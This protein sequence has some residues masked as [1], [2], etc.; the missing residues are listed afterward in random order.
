[1]NPVELIDKQKLLEW[2]DAKADAKHFGAVYAA[3]IEVFKEIQSS[4]F[5]DHSAQEEIAKLKTTIALKSVPAAMAAFMKA[6]KRA[7]ESEARALQAEQEKRDLN[8]KLLEGDRIIEDAWKKLGQ[9]E[10]ER[11][12]LKKV[13]EACVCLLPSEIDQMEQERNAL[14]ELLKNKITVNKQQI[15]NWQGEHLPSEVKKTLTLTLEER[16]GAY[17]EILDWLEGSKPE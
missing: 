4:T 2:L 11:D 8:V 16:M 14:L 15:K 1:V 10:Q 6:K 9:A 7:D 5:D 13:R 17:E 12:E 3:L